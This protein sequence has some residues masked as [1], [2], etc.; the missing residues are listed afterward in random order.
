MP[1]WE[2]LRN[3][4]AI[5]KLQTQACVSTCL[6]G[7]CRKATQERVHWECSQSHA[8][9]IKDGWDDNDA[10]GQYADTPLWPLISNDDNDPLEHRT[11]L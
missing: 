3:G 11:W 7:P 5:D 9:L 1:C 6:G 2:V 8:T 10:T 4:P